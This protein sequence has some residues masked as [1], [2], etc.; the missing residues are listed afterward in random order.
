MQ[1]GQPRHLKI[2]AGLLLLLTAVQLIGFAVVLRPPDLGWWFL[3]SLTATIVTGVAGWLLW[4]G[5]AWGYLLGVAIGI[6]WLWAAARV[7]Q[8]A[9]LAASVYLVI[10]CAILVGLLVPRSVN[11]FRTAWRA[12]SRPVAIG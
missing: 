12:R 7:F 8:V 1:G 5:R 2:E 9:E 6:Y 10:A 11:W 3:R 4:R